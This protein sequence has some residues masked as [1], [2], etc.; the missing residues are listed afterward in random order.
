MLQR[1][2]AHDAM[3]SRC[4]TSKAQRSPTHAGNRHSKGRLRTTRWRAGAPQTRLNTAPHTLETDIRKEALTLPATP[5]PPPP[6]GISFPLHSVLYHQR[7][8]H[9]HPHLQ[10][11][12]SR[13]TDKPVEPP[14]MESLFLPFIYVHS[15]DGVEGRRRA[16]QDA[17][18]RFHDGA[19]PLG[20]QPS[21]TSDPSAP[22]RRMKPP[23]PRFS[24]WQP[25][26]PWT[27]AHL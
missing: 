17:G 9:K 3:E 21:C 10:I 22:L 24:T 7:P 4:V 12:F 14:S 2:T 5:N 15:K 11:V 16:R 25:T 18:Q 13:P 1:K 26:S 23:G 20:V 6:P 19:T 27:P 8:P